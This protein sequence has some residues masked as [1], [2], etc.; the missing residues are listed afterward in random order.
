MFAD[1]LDED[2][3]DSFDD[4]VEGDIEIEGDELVGARPFFDVAFASM[5]DLQEGE[6]DAILEAEQQ[7]QQRQEEEEEELWMREEHEASSEDD[8]WTIG[9]ED[10][11]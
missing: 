1:F 11:V 10:F 7:Q 9:Y 3:F 8:N 2:S 6:E 5:H 4:E